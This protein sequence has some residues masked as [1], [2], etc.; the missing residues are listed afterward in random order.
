MSNRTDI[1]LMSILKYFFIFVN[2]LKRDV[3]IL[4]LW[5]EN[6]VVLDLYMIILRRTKKK[7]KEK[8]AWLK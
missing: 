7:K 5:N 3:I 4:S 1:P 8:V 2:F 6:I